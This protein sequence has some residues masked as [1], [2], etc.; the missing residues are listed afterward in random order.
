[1]RI[2]DKIKNITSPVIGVSTLLK[3]MLAA[4]NAWWCDRI[5]GQSYSIFDLV[6]RVQSE[7]DQI[8]F[9]RQMLIDRMGRSR[10]PVGF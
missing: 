9:R 8:S 4:I 7:T 6:R 1:M 10:S 5:F 2:T 3:N